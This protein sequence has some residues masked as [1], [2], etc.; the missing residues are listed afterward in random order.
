MITRISVS[1][2][3]AIIVIQNIF[4]NLFCK[5][6]PTIINHI[7][8]FYNKT[9]TK[10]MIYKYS[11]CDYSTVDGQNIKEFNWYKNFVHTW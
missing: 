9:S 4:A 6:M 10:F 3:G 11:Y 5:Y 7:M 2:L 8:Y 1:L